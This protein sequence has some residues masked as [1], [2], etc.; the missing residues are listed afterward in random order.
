MVETKCPETKETLLH[1]QLQEELSD[2]LMEA[3]S[4]SGAQT[5]LELCLAAKNEEKRLVNLRKCQSY[6][7]TANVGDKTK[8]NSPNNSLITPPPT[9]PI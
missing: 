7:K 4:V 6:H 3:S 2:E 9:K 1:S 8:P 5:Y